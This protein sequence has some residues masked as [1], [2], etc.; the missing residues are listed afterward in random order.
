LYDKKKVVVKTL[1]TL[2]LKDISGRLT[3]VK[4]KMSD[5]S[6]GTST[7]IIVETIEYDVPINENIFSEAWL[8]KGN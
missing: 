8:L 1:E 5:V 4:S 2:E 6:K 3:P 7:T